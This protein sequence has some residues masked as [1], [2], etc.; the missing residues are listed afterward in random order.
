M[1]GVYISLALLIVVSGIHIFSLVKRDYKLKSITK[2]FILP[3]IISFY[4]CATKEINWLVFSALV[5]GWVGDIILIPKMKTAVAIGGWVFLT[6]QILMT[7][8][9]ILKINMVNASLAMLIV[10]PIIFF[11][12]AKILIDYFRMLC[13]DDFIIIHC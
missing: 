11:I 10:L 13:F 2:V 4:L 9:I 3:L 5:C 6:G 7:V 1:I 12:Y 8:A